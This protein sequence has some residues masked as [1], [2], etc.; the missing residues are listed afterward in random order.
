MNVDNEH[1]EYKKHIEL[2]RKCRDACDGQEAVKVGGKKYLP[3]L[4]GQTPDEYD[5]YLKRALYYG[6]AGRTVQGLCGALFRK[7]MSQEGINESDWAKMQSDVTGTDCGIEQFAKKVANEVLEV[8]RTGILADMP[9]TGG[10][11]YLSYYVAEDVIN[12]RYE[13]IN[14]K[15]VLVL[16]CLHETD[17]KPDPNDNFQDEEIERIRVLEIVEGY[18]LVSL[19]DRKKD[20]KGQ[21]KYELSA[22]FMPRIRGAR[23]QEIPFVFVGAEDTGP[24]IQKPPLLDLINVNLSHYMTSAD[25]EHGAHFTGLPT[26][27]VAGFPED[28]TLKIGSETAWITSDPSAKAGFLEFTGQG[29]SALESRLKAKEQ[30]MAALG[31][32][33]LEAPRSGVEA[34]ESIRLRQSGENSALVGIAESLS[35]ALTSAVKWMVYMLS[36]PY[37]NLRLT[38]NTDFTSYRLSAQELLAL[39]QTYQG[40]GMSFD[41]FMYNLEAG[42]ILPPGRTAEDEFGLIESEGPRFTI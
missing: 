38:I 17:I 34:A 9:E 14:G 10:D 29:L 35:D 2:W 3:Q 13:Y 8:G 20:T 39:F 30:Q 33:M 42:E 7:P 40:G 11:P 6:A 15:P 27:W 23:M 21:S 22:Q 31:S 4:G 24:K 18:Y 16:V 37:E 5:A 25:L 19:Y 32:R 41:T 28:A 1:S 36:K 12:W 26:A